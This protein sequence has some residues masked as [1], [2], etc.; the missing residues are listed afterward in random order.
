MTRINLV[1]PEALCDQHLL[2]EH[3]ELTRIPNAIARGRYHLRDM[4][5]D[6]VLGAGHVRFFYNKLRFLRRRYEALHAECLRRGFRVQWFWAEHLPD[7]AH[8][9]QDYQPTPEALR[10]NQ[11]RIAQRMPSQP[12]FTPAKHEQ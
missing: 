4:P 8:L 9:W 12:R 2:A 10:L 7:D 1:P 11:E 6:Y 5:A 3:R